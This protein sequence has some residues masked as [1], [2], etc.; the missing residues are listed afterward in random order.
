MGRPTLLTGWWLRVCEELAGGRVDVLA[1][2]FDV[3]PRTMHRWF[4]G[5]IAVMRES[6][7]K[8]VRKL[9]GKDLYDAPDSPKH[10]KTRKS[11]KA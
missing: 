9:L 5:D 3:N 7:R 2:L 1:N 6:R 4:K 10:L 8:A 11:K